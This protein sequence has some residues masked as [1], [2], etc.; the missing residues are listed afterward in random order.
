MFGIVLAYKEKESSLNLNKVF[1]F[2]DNKKDL[3]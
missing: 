2:Y 3:Y 1:L